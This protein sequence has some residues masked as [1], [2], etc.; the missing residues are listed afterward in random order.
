M[1]TTYRE[2]DILFIE[3]M[4]HTPITLELC[5]W[6]GGVGDGHQLFDTKVCADS[7]SLS[8]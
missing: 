6:V 4:E 2:M 7:E 8:C 3:R 5:V 1:E